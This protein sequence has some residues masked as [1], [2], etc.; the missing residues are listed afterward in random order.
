MELELLG[1]QKGL[2]TFSLM[3]DILPNDHGDMDTV[4]IEIL[5]TNVSMFFISN[6]LFVNCVSGILV[7]REGLRIIMWN[8]QYFD[9]YM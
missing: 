1:L 2:T 9:C 6:S 3:G 7:R 8:L 4:S 5:C